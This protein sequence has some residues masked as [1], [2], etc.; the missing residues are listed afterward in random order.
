MQSMATFD[1]EKP[2]EVHDLL[3]DATLQWEPS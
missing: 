2:C 1:P 3:N